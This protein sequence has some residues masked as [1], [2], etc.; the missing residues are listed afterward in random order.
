MKTNKSFITNIIIILTVTI[1]IILPS[2]SFCLTTQTPGKWTKTTV[3]Y[4]DSIKRNTDFPI[5]VYV[6]NTALHWLLDVSVSTQNKHIVYQN[7]YT[8]Y[9][10]KGSFGLQEADRSKW[11]VFYTRIPLLYLD[12]YASFRVKI[13]ESL[14]GSSPPRSNIYN[15]T[16]V[17]IPVK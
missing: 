5:K 14:S 17:R 9:T 2:I 3:Y 6:S 15:T 12:T 11:F 10:Q 13:F 7:W 16:E 8:I 1:F 4:P